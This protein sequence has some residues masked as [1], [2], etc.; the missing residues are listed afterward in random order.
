MLRPKFFQCDHF[1]A[2]RTGTIKKIKIEIK[3]L[4]IIMILMENK[5]IIN[6][7]DFETDCTY[8]MDKIVIFISEAMSKAFIEAVYLS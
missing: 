8:L 3:R 5:R 4:N 1:A 7:L 2:I 6:Y